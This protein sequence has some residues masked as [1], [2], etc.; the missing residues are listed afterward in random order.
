MSAF[1]PKRT[2]VSVRQAALEVPPAHFQFTNLTRYNA[3]SE[4]GGGDETPF[5]WRRWTG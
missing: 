3:L 2:L 5:R 4:P 1:N